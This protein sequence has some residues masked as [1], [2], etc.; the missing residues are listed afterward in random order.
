M[1]EPPIKKFEVIVQRIVQVGALKSRNPKGV[2][3]FPLCLG[4]I[5]DA[6]VKVT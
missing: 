2:P 4:E 1:R 6:W 3:L 5:K